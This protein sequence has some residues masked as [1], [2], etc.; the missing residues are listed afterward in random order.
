MDRVSGWYRRKTQLI[1][2]GLALL[3]TLV[4]NADTIMIANSLSRDA[5]LRAAIV[6]AAQETAKEPPPEIDEAAGIEGA[7]PPSPTDSNAPLTRITQL[8]E[9]LQQLQLPIGWSR[10]DGDPRQVPDPRDIQGWFM[11]VLGLLFTTIAVSLGAPFWFD[12]LSKLINIR[13]AGKPPAEPSK[14]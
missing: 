1:V 5:V 11:K 13:A 3:V 6:A 7:P 4:V 2:L 12:T 8:R 9:E 14:A 10:R